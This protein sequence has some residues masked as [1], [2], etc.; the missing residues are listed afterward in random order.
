MNL[1]NVFSGILQKMN[2]ADLFNLLFAA[3]IGAFVGYFLSIRFERIKKDRLIQRLN[4][5][6]IS[7][8]TVHQ[9][10]LF[11][12]FDDLLPFWLL[13]G[14]DSFR[15][16]DIHDIVEEVHLSKFSFY[17]SPLSTEHFYFFFEKLLDSDFFVS[18][19]Y[20]YKD[21]KSLNS[22]LGY[23]K[24]ASGL[25]KIS[26]IYEYAGLCFTLLTRSIGLIKNLRMIN[27]KEIK[28]FDPANEAMKPPKD[29]ETK[30]LIL[31]ELYKI[32]YNDLER[33]EIFEDYERNKFIE[34]PELPQISKMIVDDRNK[35]WQKYFRRAKKVA[36]T[37]KD[38]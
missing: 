32:K 28:C 23:L 22:C 14:E 6:L 3:I 26:A 11:L 9:Y 29:Y 21:I 12:Y 7:E 16:N 15:N 4:C 17:R 34:K 37:G 19:A 25:N 1:Q 2:L 38:S 24:D 36:K 13:R 35:M 33:L 31:L 5:V 10:K 27:G 20:Y 18:L 30:Y 8:I